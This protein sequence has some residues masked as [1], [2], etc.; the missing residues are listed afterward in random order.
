MSQPS[1]AESVLARC[2]RHAARSLASVG[3]AARRVV[4]ESAATR[5]ATENC[6]RREVRG[7]ER[8]KECIP[9][10]ITEAAFF[11]QA[12]RRGSFPVMRRI[13]SESGKPGGIY[14]YYQF[15][16]GVLTEELL[17]GEFAEVV[18]VQD[19]RGFPRQP[20]ALPEAAGSAERSEF[21]S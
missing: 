2:A 21:N 7:R 15:W 12:C 10:K 20:Q 19:W 11:A 4:A 8:R 14:F 6:R 3:G 1:G 18:F 9:M 5:S 13:S 16:A 17:D